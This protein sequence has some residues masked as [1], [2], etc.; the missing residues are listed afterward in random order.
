M[1]HDAYPGYDPLGTYAHEPPSWQETLRL[2]IVLAG[3]LGPFTDHF[4]VHS[5]HARQLVM[6]DLPATSTAHVS[7]VP[8][9]CPEPSVAPRVPRSG[10]HIVSLGIVSIVKGVGR[11]LDAFVHVRAARPDARLTFAGHGG[12]IEIAHWRAHAAALGIGHAVTFEGYVDE[13]E[14]QRLL[15]DGT[16]AVQLRETTN[17]ECSAAVAECLAAGLPVVVSTMGAHAE[18]PPDVA[19][20]VPNGVAPTALAAMLLQLL[21]SPAERTARA[22]AGLDYARANSV[23]VVA[24]RVLEELEPR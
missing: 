9:G 2:G 16:V 20:Q 19:V 21:D 15:A 3:Q 4:L 13:A 7:V 11:L 6:A 10:S 1:L 24:E 23:D 18:L 14:W 17:G 5:E 8:F 22:E 12:P